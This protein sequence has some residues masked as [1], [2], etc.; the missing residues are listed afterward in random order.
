MWIKIAT[1]VYLLPL[2]TNRKKYFSNPTDVTVL[3]VTISSSSLLHYAFLFSSSFISIWHTQTELYIPHII[4][5]CFAMRVRFMQS[6]FFNL[7]NFVSYP[8]AHTNKTLRQKKKILR[9]FKRYVN[10]IC[11]ATYHSMFW[12]YRFLIW[13]SRCWQLISRNRQHIFFLS[14]IPVWLFYVQSKMHRIMTVEPNEW[15][16]E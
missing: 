4:Y 11:A 13:N 16:G 6:I 1:K 5:E 7:N 10:M 8:E 3:G 9:R 2:P 12:I 15:N 14:C